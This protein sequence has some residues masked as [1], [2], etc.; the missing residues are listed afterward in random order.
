MGNSYS[1]VSW[2]VN[3]GAKRVNLI[4][5]WPNSYARTAN[6]DKVP[7]TIS[8]KDDYPDQWGYS[9]EPK[10]N[11]FKWIKLL[12]EPN[13]KYK[14]AVEFVRGSH[15]QLKSLGKTADEVVA[16]YLKF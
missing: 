2:A 6:S 11:P 9:V 3:A 10:N 4:I 15:S 8:Y 5:D 14:N 13:L 12:L 16:D 7:S 1:G